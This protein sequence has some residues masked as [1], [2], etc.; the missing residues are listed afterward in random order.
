MNNIEELKKVR[1]DVELTA[2]V[3]AIIGYTSSLKAGEVTQEYIDRLNSYY[4]P[5]LAKAAG[6]SY[7]N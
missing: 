2:A 6:V 1:E 3:N 7:E 5:N 4:V